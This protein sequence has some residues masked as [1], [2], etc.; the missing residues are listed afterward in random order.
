MVEQYSVVAKYHSLLIHLPVDE[1][2]GCFEFWDNRNKAIMNIC[3]Q[4]FVQPYVF[5]PHKC[6]SEITG[7][8]IMC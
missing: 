1:H 3:I 7:S 6:K 8:Y 2:L 4:V 5:I